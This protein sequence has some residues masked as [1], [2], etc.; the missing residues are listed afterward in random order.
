MSNYQFGFHRVKSTDDA[1]NELTDFLSTSLDKGNKCSVVFLDLA[2]EIDTVPIPI[3]L[4]KLERIDIG[5]N[6]LG[7]LKDYLSDSTK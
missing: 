5:G 7:L 2:K 6:Q 4:D 3:L 1:V